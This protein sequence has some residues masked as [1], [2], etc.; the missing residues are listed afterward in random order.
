MQNGRP[1]PC[2]FFKITKF[3][4]HKMTVNF[5][6]NFLPNGYPQS[7]SGCYGGAVTDRT[8]DGARVWAMLWGT[9]VQKHATFY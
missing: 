9:P 7:W 4:K 2:C 8:Q 5:F 1:A 3:S 6:E